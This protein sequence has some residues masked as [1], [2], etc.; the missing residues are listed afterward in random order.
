VSVVVLA[1]GDECGAEE[2]DIILMPLL[3][4]VLAGIKRVFWLFGAG[5]EIR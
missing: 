4:L 2:T 1:E 5:M 3:V